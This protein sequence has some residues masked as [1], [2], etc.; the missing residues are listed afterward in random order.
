MYP[1]FA[2]SMIGM[3]FPHLDV[4]DGCRLI[5][6]PEQWASGAGLMLGVSTFDLRGI[7]GPVCC[8]KECMVQFDGVGRRFR[9][10]GR[11]KHEC[12]V[13]ITDTDCDTPHTTV[14]AKVIP[15]STGF[16]LVLNIQDQGDE[17]LEQYLLA[18]ETALWACIHPTPNQPQ[19]DAYRKKLGIE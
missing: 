15:L 8:G 4:C 9:L 14:V 6:S 1:L 12:K 11:D 10:V 16:R 17:F 2:L 5:H 13:T 18:L 7:K 3:N 19:F